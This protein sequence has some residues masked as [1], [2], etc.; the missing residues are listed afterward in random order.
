MPNV[1]PV[2]AA[3]ASATT[4]LQAWGATDLAIAFDASGCTV[5]VTSEC[6]VHI[7]RS[8]NPDPS[9]SVLEATAVILK[10]QGEPQ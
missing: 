1:D 7:G 5:R 4:A 3:T 9:L 8:A 10:G 2:D 6:G